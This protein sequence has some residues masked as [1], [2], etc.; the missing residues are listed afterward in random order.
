[1]KRSW[2]HKLHGLR[3]DVWFQGVKPPSISQL[4]AHD[5]A[6]Q[7]VMQPTIALIEQALA[8]LSQQFPFA[9]R[10]HSAT[11]IE[12]DIDAP[13][14]ANDLEIPI[15]PPSYAWKGGTARAVLGKMFGLAQLPPRDLDLLRLGSAWNDQDATVSARYMAEDWQRGHGVEIR[16]TMEAYLETRDLSVNEC[17]LYAD[18]MIVSPMALFDSLGQVLRPCRYQPG[19][20]S[21]PP[22]LNT[23]TLLKMLRLRSEQLSLGESWMLVGIADG[24][25]AEPLHIAVQLRKALQQGV[26]VAELYVEELAAIGLLAAHVEHQLWYTLRELSDYLFEG[27]GFFPMLSADQLEFIGGLPEDNETSES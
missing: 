21:K 16:R 11:R 23:L 14:F 12:F 5:W 22:S 7:H 2:P 8:A 9:L 1:M 17:A 19:S 10:T 3:R 27:L 25:G 20:L 15:P 4:R 6:Q 18:R 13:F 26:R 24:R